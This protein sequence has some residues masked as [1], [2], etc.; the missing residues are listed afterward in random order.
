MNAVNQLTPVDVVRDECVFWSH[1]VYR[2]YALKMLNGRESCTAEEWEKLQTD[3]GVEIQGVNM[4]YDAPTWI[5]EK[6]ASDGDVEV[7]RQWQP[8]KPEIMKEDDREGYVWTLKKEGV[9]S[10]G[11]VL[12]PKEPTKEMLE[13]AWEAPPAGGPSGNRRSFYEKQTVVYKAMIEAAEG[14]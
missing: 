13:A 14:E 4:E 12:V 10:E 7:C 6:Y 1:P 5:Y 8:S 11:F 3:L 9:A 2:E